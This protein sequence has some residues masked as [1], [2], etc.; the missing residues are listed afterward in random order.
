M[1]GLDIG[2]SNP[3]TVPP[4]ATGGFGGDLLAFGNTSPSQPPPQP[5]ANTGGLGGD[6]MGFGFPNQ[7]PAPS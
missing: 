2:G 5:P 1:L 3:T 4:A 6:L 7:T